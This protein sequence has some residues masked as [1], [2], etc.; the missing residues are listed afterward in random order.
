[1]SLLGIRHI[2]NPLLPFFFFLKHTTHFILTV[3]L[4][5][6]YKKYFWTRNL[7]LIFVFYKQYNKVLFDGHL[8]KSWVRMTID[9]PNRRGKTPQDAHATEKC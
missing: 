6:F 1:M 5:F 2:W 4:L 3:L 9:I 8:I 7:I